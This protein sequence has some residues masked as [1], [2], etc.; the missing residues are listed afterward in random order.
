MKR[1]AVRKGNYIPPS[2]SSSLPFLID[3]AKIIIKVIEGV[4][5]K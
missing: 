1:A 5:V 4:L 3:S 2:S